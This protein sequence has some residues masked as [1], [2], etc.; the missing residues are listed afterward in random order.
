MLTISDNNITIVKKDTGSIT[1][2]LDN[3]TLEDGDIVYFTVAEE[4]ESP[5]PI[6]SKKITEFDDEGAANIS[7]SVD[8]TNI[9]EGT[10]YYDIQVNLA[11]GTVDTIIGPAKFKIV[12][13]VT[14]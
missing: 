4:L 8:D 14:V 5:N 3:H 12:G 9:D 1:V 2:T 7:L 6:I 11:D 13:G 10:Y